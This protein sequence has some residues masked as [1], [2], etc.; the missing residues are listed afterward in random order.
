MREPNVIERFC[1]IGWLRGASLAIVLVAVV[2][3]ATGRAEADRRI[4]GYTYPYMT[5]PQGGFEIE[6]YLDA[7]FQELDDPG[8]TAIED[9]YE[10]DWE[11][12]VEAEYG[13]TDHWDFGFYNVFRQKP[14]S[15]LSYRGVKLRTRYRFAEEGEWFIDP[16]V[17][18]EV[19]YKF[20]EVELEQRLILGKWIGSVEI[21]LNLKF[22]EEFVVK[23]GDEIEFA[24]V[25]S[26]GVGYHFN[27]NWAI[28]LEYLGELVLEDGK[29]EHF[30]HYVGPTLSLAGNHFW[31][32]I[33]GQYQVS[34]LNGEPEFQLRSLFAVVF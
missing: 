25:P 29:Y 30:A 26:L 15:D 12:Q 10:V 5:L 31:W 16:A 27:E 20:D 9:D 19:G 11:H 2:V 32:T 18:C 7:R 33:A 23:G 13:I 8:T 24:F 4:F 6:H 3:G 21:A 1:R 22:E 34:R 17:Y 28:G 14:F